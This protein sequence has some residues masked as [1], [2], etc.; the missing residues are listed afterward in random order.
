M[1]VL[2]AIALFWLCVHG[3]Q[4]YHELTS[5]D[6]PLLPSSAW[7]SRPR[8]LTRLRWRKTEVVVRPLSISVSSVQANEGNRLLA[9]R[10]NTSHSWMKWTR[11]AYDIGVASCVVGQATAVVLVTL[12]VA[13]LAVSMLRAS[14]LTKPISQSHLARRVEETMSTL[15]ATG[16]WDLIFLQPIVSLWLKLSSFAQTRTSRYLV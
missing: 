14:T 4:A 7:R 5:R 8:W 13:Y 11:W 2:H 12:T 1:G 15:A 10:L 3:G 9:A 16:N 6:T